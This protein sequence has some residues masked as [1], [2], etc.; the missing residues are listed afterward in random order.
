MVT[1]DSYPTTSTIT[2]KTTLQ[3][4]WTSGS[5]VFAGY[6]LPSDFGTMIG[7][8]Y[9]V[10]N[11]GLQYKMVPFDYRDFREPTQNSFIWRFYRDDFNLYY[12]EYYYTLVDTN[13]IYTA[14]STPASTHVKVFLPFLPQSANAIRFE[15]NAKPTV[16]SSS[17][18]VCDIPDEYAITTVPY[19]ATSMMLQV[20]GE[21][22]VASALYQTGYNN[23][24]TM[25]QGFNQLTKELVYNQRVRTISD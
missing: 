2:T 17:T 3:Y 8:Y 14:S 24:E 23:T 21:P 6:A 1:V 15:Y 20:R 13:L 18:D 5:R 12:G 4:S 25:F 22:D 19:I 10:S 16:L 9:D 7:A 11:T